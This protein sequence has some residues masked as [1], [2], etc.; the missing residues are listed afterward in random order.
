M[1]GAKWFQGSKLNYAENLL[2]FRND[3]NAIE[4][5]CEDQLPRSITYN[6]LYKF[7]AQVSHAFKNLGLKKGDRVCAV[8]PNMPETVICMLAASSLGMIWS[9]CSPDFGAKGILDRFKQIN[10]SILITV[11]GYFFKG[12][13]YNIIDKILNVSETINSIENVVVVKGPSPRFAKTVT[14]NSARWPMGVD[15][16]IVTFIYSVASI[17][18]STEYAFEKE[19]LFIVT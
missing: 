8:M 16:F 5:Y 4:Y 14:V 11:D 19:I 3:D 1:P 2:K 6:Q 17:S 9:S 12:K 7:V 18:T 13:K 10:P 15:G